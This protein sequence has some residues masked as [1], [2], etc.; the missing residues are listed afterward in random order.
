[1]MRGHSVFLGVFTAIA[2]GACTAPHRIESTTPI[3]GYLVMGPRG[4]ARYGLVEGDTIPEVGAHALPTPVRLAVEDQARAFESDQG[5]T[6]YF[7]RHS[8]VIALFMRTCSTNATVEDGD[9]MA[10]FSADGKPKGAAATPL[11]GYYTAIYPLHR[12]PQ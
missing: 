1:M 10:A 4:A 12:A 11:W 2:L 7:V 3:S 5:C 6:R 8:V 9:G